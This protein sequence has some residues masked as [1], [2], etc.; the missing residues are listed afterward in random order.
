MRRTLAAGTVALSLFVPIGCGAAADDTETAPEARQG[1]GQGMLLVAEGVQRAAPATDA[2]VSPA[3][4]GL[5]AFGHD[6]LA[7]MGDDRNLVV[8]PLS[9]GYAFGMADAGARGETKA[10]IEK[11]LGFPAG[12]PHQAMNALTQQIGTHDTPPPRLKPGEQQSPGTAK[13]PVVSLANG[14]FVDHRL[15]VEPDFLRVLAEQYGAGARSIDFAGPKASDEINAWVRK[16]TADRIP[17][18]FDQLDPDV[19]MV[20]ANAV[21]LKADWAARFDTTSTK[22]ES[23]RR[24]AGAVRVPT[25]HREAALR[26]TAG[27]GYQAVELPYAG[28]ELAM[29]VLVPTGATKPADLLAPQTLAAVGSGLTS[30][31]VHVALPRWDF[32]TDTDLKPLLTKLGMSVPFDETKAD[33]SGISR[34]KRMFIS[35]AVHRA[36]ITVDENGTEAAAVTGLGMGIVSAPPPVEATV[37]ADRPFAFA[38]V[39]T[40]TKA[41]LFLG[42]VT[43][44]TQH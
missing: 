7:A 22:P 35:Q 24:E 9:I 8:S 37:R 12:G 39:H 44:P 4:S 41:P 16:Q 20:L 2:P 28:G 23:F 18:L 34:T 40:K 33:F 27:A 11:T 30:K 15:Q 32:G 26:H 21:Y 13:P 43:D 14:L 6:L 36:N 31:R 29:W 42:Q 3:I 1:T 25:M 19:A 38:I 10:E 5:T 17:K